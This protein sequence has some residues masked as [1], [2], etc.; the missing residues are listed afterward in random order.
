MGR[1]E[2]PILLAQILIQTIRSKLKVR[3]RPKKTPLT[4]SHEILQTLLAMFRTQK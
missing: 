1:P 4:M 2:V 3:F